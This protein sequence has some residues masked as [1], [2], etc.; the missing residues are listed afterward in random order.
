[1]EYYSAIKKQEIISLAAKRMELEIIKLT[2]ISH[3]EK[4]NYCLVY[5]ESRPKDKEW[6]KC[7]TRTIWE[8][9]PEEERAK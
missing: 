5:T 4:D 2:E 7:K 3:T 9:E 8:W 1:M 6:Y